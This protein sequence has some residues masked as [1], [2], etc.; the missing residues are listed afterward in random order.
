MALK[1]LQLPSQRKPA[2]PG[3]QKEIIDSGVQRYGLN[4]FFVKSVHYMD[5]MT[6]IRSN[7]WRSEI[8][9]YRDIKQRRFILE[10]RN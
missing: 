5:H 10:K 3:G 2:F 8:L 6:S 9:V 4:R 7:D 1:A